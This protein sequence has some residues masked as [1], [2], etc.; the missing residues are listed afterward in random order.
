MEQFG[1]EALLES[2]PV[3]FVV[4]LLRLS[5]QSEIV[6]SKLIV[7]LIGFLLIIW[8]QYPMEYPVIKACWWLYEWSK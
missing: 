8:L 1:V 5:W 6:I 3:I 4:L 7:S 2:F